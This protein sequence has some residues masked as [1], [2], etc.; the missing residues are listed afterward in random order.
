[1]YEFENV[2]G[3]IEVYYNGE[4]LFTADD[5]AEAEQEI[6]EREKNKGVLV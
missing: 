4:F 6:K 5:Y 2:R 1:M 3:H